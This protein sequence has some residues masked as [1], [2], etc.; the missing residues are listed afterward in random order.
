[1]S[2][3]LLL[4]I[5]V[6]ELPPLAVGET[7]SQL[8]F[9]GEKL[10]TASHIDYESIDIFGSS[11]R[12]VL[13]AEGVARNQRKRIEKEMGPPRSVVLTQSG[14]LTPEG[15]AYL[16]AKGAKKGNLG[17]EKLTKGEY[18]YL[19]RKIKGEETKRILPHLLVQLVQSLSFPKSMRWGEG[20]FSFGRPIRSLLALFGEEVVSFRLAGIISG[21]KTRGHPYLSP[22]V[23][24]IRNPREYFSGLRKSYVMVDQEERREL[25]GNQIEEMTIPLKKS[26]PQ[27]KILDDEELLEE[28]VYLVE[29]PTLFL[30]EFNPEFLSLPVPVLRACLRDYQKHFSLADG[31][32]ILPYFAGIREGNKEHLE[33]VIQG[34]QRVLNARLKDAQFFFSE[35][36]KKFSQEMK[37]P[38]EKAF[39]QLKEIVVHNKLGSYYDKTVRLHSLS[40]EIFFQV[41]EN[42]NREQELLKRVWEAANLCKVDLVTQMVK[43]LPSLQGTMGGEY[44]RGSGKD[45][46]VAQAISEHRLP[47]FSNDK[48]PQTLEG[49]ILALADRLDTVVG[50]FWAGFIPTGSEDPWG[51]RREVQ[52]MVEILL[53]WGWRINLDHLIEHALEGYRK[54][55]RETLPAEE[56]IPK[57]KGFFEIRIRNLLKEKGIGTHE[58][59]AVLNVGFADVTDAV[60]RGEALGKICQRPEFKDE[61]IATVRLLNILKQAQEWKVRIP[62]TVR[63]NF[64]RETEE[65]E[66]YELWIKLGGEIESLLDKQEY[67]EAYEKLSRFKEPIHNFFDKVLV[68]CE[69][70][71]LR[72]NRLSLLNGI[73]KLFTR[74]AD[75]T[76]LQ[77]K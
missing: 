41:V 1:M 30:G 77:V 5:R 71:N 75:F 10:L 39:P 15:K 25:I 50:C 12:L 59:R 61:V 53:D 45:P 29:Y 70:E 54:N 46:R 32:R 52:G 4:E 72:E 13:W 68:M 36:M 73:G 44:A 31:D 38:L 33:E 67:V 34:N 20:D 35:D 64:L 43:E 9:E 40:Q 2:E 24:S 47:R 18:V 62:Q 48:L 14:Q 56:V 3:I 74:I 49:A 66:L 8:K 21:R 69:E 16:K 28:M 17:I 42:K 76:Q 51:L 58:I 37:K 22:S 60:E 57:I 65:K 23:F 55:E 26:R 11:R 27:A 63:E 6:E 19:K 7:L